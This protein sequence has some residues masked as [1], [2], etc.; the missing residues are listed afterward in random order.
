[1]DSVSFV[2]WCKD[3]SLTADLLVISALGMRGMRVA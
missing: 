1:M 2:A 3:A